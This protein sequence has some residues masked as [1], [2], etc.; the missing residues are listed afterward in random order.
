[1]SRKKFSKEEVV[2][3]LLE[4]SE[5]DVEPSSESSAFIDPSND[6]AS[7][8]STARPANRSA[9]VRRGTRV[10]R[11]DDASQ[12]HRGLATSTVRTGRSVSGTEK[13]SLKCR[14]SA[15]NSL[16]IST[17]PGTSAALSQDSH[18]LLRMQWKKATGTRADPPV[19]TKPGLCFPA[20]FRVYHT[21]VEYC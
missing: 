17:E 1:M 7:D 9:P 8:E 13:R 20:C 6:A 15:S 16:S 14:P 10:R 12:R 18:L 4:S 19:S 5:S 11:H 21:Q 2:K 3:L